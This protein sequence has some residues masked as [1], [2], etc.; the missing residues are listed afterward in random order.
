MKIKEFQDNYEK[1]GADQSC[2]ELMMYLE[3]KGRTSGIAFLNMWL[4]AAC[5]VDFNEDLRLSALALL[6]PAK[7]YLVDYYRFL[8]QT[9]V[10][11]LKR[12]TQDELDQMLFGYH[13]DD[14]GSTIHK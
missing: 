2:L 14:Y 9:R 6:M 3:E 8:E 12:L 13:F 11:L 10:H 1:L 7:L 4:T 5:E